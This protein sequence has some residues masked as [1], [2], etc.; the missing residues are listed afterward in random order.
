VS[1]K[2]FLQSIEVKNP[3]AQNWDEMHGN[4]HVRFCDHCAKN[5]SN[6]SEI[7]RKDARRLVRDSNG[8]L[9]VRYIVDPRTKLP[10]FADQLLKITR[11]TPGL[12]AGIMT[13][14]LSL[15][16]AAYSQGEPV[17]S[18]V[19]RP[20]DRAALTSGS[21][22][23]GGTLTD[24]NGAVIVSA[25]VSA[26][27]AET[28][29]YFSSMTDAE[30][31][32]QFAGLPA[33]R[34]KLRFEAIGFEPREIPFIQVSDGESARFDS[35][36]AVPGVTETVNVGGVK[37]TDTYVNGGSICVVTSGPRNGLVAAVESEDLDEVKALVQMG[38][39][40]NTRDKSENGISPLH[41]AVENGSLEIAEYLIQHGAKINAR[42]N[43]KRTPLMMIDSDATVELARVLLQAGAKPEAVDKQ[44]VTVLMHYVEFADAEV[45][46]LL[47]AYGAQ[48]N[49][50]DREG[51]TALMIAAE[52]GSVETVEVLLQAGAD[53][54]KVSKHGESAFGM[55][56]GQG[57]RDLL[58][59]Y[60]GVIPSR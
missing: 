16:P 5:V 11:R 30:G 50:V 45:L 56:G 48:V 6:L 29:Q 49:A 22:D 3:C 15:A 18:A 1:K 59:T 44:K 27:N 24:Q 20:I 7:T 4:D 55:A 17:A 31:R 42:D 53:V 8:R 52:N 33:G 10:V 13:A 26:S 25:L 2:D 47:I 19:V 32:Y 39:R 34:Y 41:A 57:V 23:L 51:K 38:A 60:G 58:A 46:R 40:I 9:C 12:A 21:G 36:L 54:N 43:L 28:G 37:S 35:Q 14:S